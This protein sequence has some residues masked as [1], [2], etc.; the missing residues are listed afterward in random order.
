[1]LCGGE[2]DLQEE[3]LWTWPTLAANNHLATLIALALLAAGLTATTV[4]GARDN[5]ADPS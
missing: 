5:H 1:M 2:M 3:S 4:T